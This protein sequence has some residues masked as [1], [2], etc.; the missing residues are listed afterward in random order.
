MKEE[1]PSAT[2]PNYADHSEAKVRKPA[3]PLDGKKSISHFEARLLQAIKDRVLIAVM[4]ASL[5][6]QVGILLLGYELL[7]SLF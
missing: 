1:S 3:E 4:K 7:N 5:Q 6:L 2:I